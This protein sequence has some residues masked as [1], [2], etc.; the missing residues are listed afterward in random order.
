MSKANNNYM[1]DYSKNKESRHLS[2]TVM[3]EFRNDYVKRKYSENAKLVIKII[4]I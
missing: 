3:Y 1:E 4:T 2:K